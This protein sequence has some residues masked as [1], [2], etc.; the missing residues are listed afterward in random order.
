MGG[1]NNNPDGKKG[2]KSVI[3][4]KSDSPCPDCGVSPGQFHTPGCDVERCS[5]CGLQAIG[6]DCAFEAD[7][8]R[9]SWSGE[10]PGVAECREFGWYSKRNHG[11]VGYVPCDKEDPEA[12]EDLNR[13]YED[14]S[15]EW[16]VEKQRWVLKTK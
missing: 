4:S 10:W 3:H 1:V 16:S 11:G 14:E 9:V 12:S 6:C 15:V 13:L 2:R 8:N 7:S 5:Q